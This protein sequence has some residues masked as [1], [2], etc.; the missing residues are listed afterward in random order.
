M[1]KILIV[2]ASIFMG[3]SS[4]VS[5]ANSTSDDAA[6][7]YRHTYNHKNRMFLP[8][9]R[10]NNRQEH[11]V[12]HNAQCVAESCRQNIAADSPYKGAACPSD[13]RKNGQTSHIR[14]CYSLIPAHS[15]RKNLVRIAVTQD[16]LLPP[17]KCRIQLL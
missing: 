1:K 5:C 11:A 15:H 7:Q 2:V 3:V 8:H 16:Q 9:S 17:F 6:Q 4:F 10:N 14:R 13:I 12:D